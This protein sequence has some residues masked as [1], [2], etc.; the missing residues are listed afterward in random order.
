MTIFKR[1]DVWHMHIEINGREIRQ[2]CRT[3]DERAALE[4]HDKTRADLWRQHRLG[5]KPRRTWA[6]A[7]EK[8]LLMSEAKRSHSDDLR[9]NKFWSKEFK[10][11]GVVYIDE[12]DSDLHDEIIEDAAETPTRF[13]ELP[14]NATLNRRTAYLRTV[15]NKAARKWAW[16]GVSPALTMKSEVERVRYISHEEFAN[17][18]RELPH[19]YNDMAMLAVATGLRR[20]NVMNLT[21][22]QVDLRNNLIRF[23]SQ[24]MKNGLAFSIPLTQ[25]ARGVLEANHGADPMRVFLRPDGG[26]VNGVPTKMWFAALDRAKISDFRWHDLRHTW[27]SWLRQDGESLDKIQELGGWEEASMVQRYAHLSVKHLESSAS[28]VD[29]MLAGLK[30]ATQKEHSGS[31]R[32]VSTSAA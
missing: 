2:S 21:W 15:L 4:L 13:G 30:P 23:P 9:H 25:T 28:R 1:G 22:P 3:K 32:L 12:I 19:P 24:V 18:Y 6:E 20:S 29:R 11:L 31:L 14:A 8:F 7:S 27:A 16:I 17:L 26:P 10:R 5:E